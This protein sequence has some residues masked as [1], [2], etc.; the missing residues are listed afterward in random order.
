[1]VSLW[2]WCALSRGTHT[3][4][5]VE[6]V[7]G[8]VWIVGAAAPGAWEEVERLVLGEGALLVDIRYAARSRWFPQWNKSWLVARFGSRYTH[9]R[10]LANANYKD[11]SLP[12]KLVDPDRGVAGA[13]ELVM[14]GFFLVLLCAC[15]GDDPAC[16]CWLV[17][18]LITQ[19]VKEA[20]CAAS[21]LRFFRRKR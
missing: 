11:H 3:E 18:S 2:R 4:G 17:A 19:G 5:T 16:H 15:R 9:E 6:G 13:V 1:L 14:K 21:P 10:G 8:D 12:I 7:H 20:R